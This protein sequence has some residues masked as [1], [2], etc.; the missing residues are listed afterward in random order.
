[1]TAFRATG[2]LASASMESWWSWSVVGTA[3]LFGGLR[4]FVSLCGGCFCVLAD[5]ERIRCG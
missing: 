1:M 5:N 3:H 2:D 4:T